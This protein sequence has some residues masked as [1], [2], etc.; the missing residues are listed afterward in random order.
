M[1]MLWLPDGDSASRRLRPGSGLR[2]RTVGE[3]VNFDRGPSPG[4]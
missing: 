3:L 4:R 2:M 1:E